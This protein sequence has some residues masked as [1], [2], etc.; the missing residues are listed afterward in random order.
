MGQGTLFHPAGALS[1]A[2]ALLALLAPA[3]AQGPLYRERWGYL[4][5]E[6]RRHELARELAGRSAE[7]HRRTAALLAEPDGGM[8]FLP[9]AKALAFLRGVTADPAFVLRCTIGAYVLPEVCDPDGDHEQCRTTNVSVCLPFGVPLPG[10]LSFAVVVENAA[11]EVAWQG[12]ITDRTDERDVGMGKATVS[13]PSGDLPDGAYAM[14]LRTRLDDED[15]RPTDPVCRWTFHV[16]RGYQARG[17]RAL[18]DAHARQEGLAAVERA[19][20]VGAAGQVAR[21]YYGEPWAV[22]SDGVQDLVRLERVLANLAAG[23][24]AADGLSGDLV[25]ALPAAEGPPFACVLRRADGDGPRPLVVVAAGAPAFDA[26][27]RRPT[28]PASRDPAWLAH[29]F[30]AF[31]RDRKWHLACLESPGVGRDFGRCLREALAALPAFLPGGAG[32]VL[33]VAEREAAAVAALHLGDLHQ[34]LRGVVLVGSG[35]VPGPMWR[36]LGAL[37]V[38][39]AAA[40]GL[41]EAMLQPVFAFV[42]AERRDGRWQGDVAW[43]TDDRPAWC[44]ALPQLAPAIEAFAAELLA[45]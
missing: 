16:L 28:A 41:G 20:L 22:Q 35:A 4:H 31:A 33:L 9:V 7:D 30:A 3:A 39:Y 36:Q 8:P 45:R 14:T 44:L 12:E 34:A 19:V 11:G 13:V 37:P 18:R 24:A 29:E 6:A 38:R 10:A 42:D 25:L 26:T 21:A 27:A 32:P 5:L 1:S 15:P 40:H 23:A 43:L 2:G 17:E